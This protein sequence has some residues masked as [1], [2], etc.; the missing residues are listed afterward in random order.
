MRHLEIT[1]LRVFNVMLVALCWGGAAVCA[2]TGGWLLTVAGDA[3][4]AGGLLCAALVYD[5]RT[6]LGMRKN[7]IEDAEKRGMGGYA[8][9]L[10]ARKF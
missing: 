5:I 1:K 7:F 3:I 6:A 9:E 2:L 10:R 8:A 4:I